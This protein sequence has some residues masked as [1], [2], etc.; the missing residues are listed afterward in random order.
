MCSIVIGIIC[1]KHH[2]ETKIIII[3]R[4]ETEIMIRQLTEK[5]FQVDKLWMPRF[6][7]P[8]WKFYVE[9]TSYISSKTL[10]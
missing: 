7:V 4:V 5:F 8:M 1:R 3:V 9:G 2:E 6:L 10:S